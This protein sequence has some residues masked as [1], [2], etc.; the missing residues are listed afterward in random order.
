M[1]GNALGLQDVVSIGSDFLPAAEL[2]QVIQAADVG[3]V[4]YRRDVFT[5]GILPT[6]LLEYMALGV[7]AIVA[8]TPGISAYV[9]ETM[10]DFFT[11]EDVDDLA[12]RIRALYY[13]RQR[14]DALARSTAQF[15]LRYNWPSQ[16]ASYIHLV[17][18][19]ARR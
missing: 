6:K 12:R 14:L 18:T 7:P 10:V 15:N 8:R 5:D 19:L 1:F 16:A 11:P 2:A 4:P 9:D 13:D 17:D 3:L